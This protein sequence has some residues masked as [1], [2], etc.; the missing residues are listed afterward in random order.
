MAEPA[1]PF[2]LARFLQAQQGIYA[3]ALGDLNRGL[4]QSHWMWFIFPQATGLGQSA[5]ARRYAIGSAAE[6]RAYL[7]DP[8]LGPRLEECTLAVLA[9]AGRSA[10]SILGAIDAM[11][12]RS[13]MTLFGALAGPHSA[14]ARCLNVFFEGQP[15]PATLAFLER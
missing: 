7:A 12:L 15:D 13:S 6:G 1:D 14:F 5:M 3:Q 2:D 9:H 4:K 11:K 10:E 8:L